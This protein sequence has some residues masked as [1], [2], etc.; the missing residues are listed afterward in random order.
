MLA[1]V[2]SELLIPNQL[3]YNIRVATP[4]LRTDMGFYVGTV[5]RDIKG[6]VQ[7]LT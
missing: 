2:A 4:S 7:V 1:G 5:W 3:R 6:R